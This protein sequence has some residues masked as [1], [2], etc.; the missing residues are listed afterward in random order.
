MRYPCRKKDLFRLA[1]CLFLVA[2]WPAAAKKIYRFQDEN[3]VWNFSDTPPA[4]SRPVE[5]KQLRIKTPAEKVHLQQRAGGDR[6]EIFAVN[7]Y[8]GPVEIELSMAGAENVEPDRPLPLRVVVGA[9]SERRILLV[10]PQN[11]QAGW[12]YEFNARVALGDPAAR[13]SPAALY[14]VPFAEGRFPVS[15][16]F[17]GKYT[18]NTEGNEFAVDIAMPE[19]TPLVAARDGVVMDVAQDFFDSGLD[20]QLMERANVVRILHDDGTIAT[21]AHLQLETARLPAGSRVR[22]GQYIADSGNSG[23]SSGPHLHFVVQKNGGM[24]MR[25]VPFQFVNGNGVAVTPDEGLVLF[26]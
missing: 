6:H 7:G 1:L 23:Y 12:S 19:G 18:H 10:A 2:A 24:T 26:P 9:A 5:T 8:H 16:G 21:Y 20:Q 11:P 14:R 15:Q 3:G 25:S 22:A 17:N 4:T 13:H